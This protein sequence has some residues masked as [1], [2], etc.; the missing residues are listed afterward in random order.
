MLHLHKPPTRAYGLCMV[1]QAVALGA[2]PPKFWLDFELIDRRLG[3]L[4]IEPG[5]LATWIG[6]DESTV[7]R[8]RRRIV[9]PSLATVME[10]SERLGVTAN[11]LVIRA[12]ASETES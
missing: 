1:A 11:L 10:L 6:V 3:E 2:R 8:L 7:N 9:T 5:E 12:S 4:D